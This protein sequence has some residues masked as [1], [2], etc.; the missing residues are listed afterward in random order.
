MS[1]RTENLGNSLSLEHP[2][3]LSREDGVRIIEP[4]KDE[5]ERYG[6]LYDKIIFPACAAVRT[7]LIGLGL[8]VEVL[9]AKLAML[10]Q[11]E[12][13]AA[14]YVFN[15][16]CKV[17]GGYVSQK[18]IEHFNFLIEM[19]IGSIAVSSVDEALLAPFGVA[20][21]GKV[22]FTGRYANLADSM[23]YSLLKKIFKEI[24]KAEDKLWKEKGQEGR[25]DTPDTG[26]RA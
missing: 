3:V 25:Q 12:S 23:E 7:E 21:V 11:A 16:E 18:N 6:I 13:Q 8:P 1:F 22:L 10:R 14:E 9:E 26:A 2:E 24:F 17:L 19:V 5:K 15:I 20:A 4:E